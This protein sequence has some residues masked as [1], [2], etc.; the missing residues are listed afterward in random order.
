MKGAQSHGEQLQIYFGEG[1]VKASY[2]SQ[3]SELQI[4]KKKLYTDTCV[5]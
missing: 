2:N 1:V 5:L 4:K 3:W